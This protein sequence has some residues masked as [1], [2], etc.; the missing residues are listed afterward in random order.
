MKELDPKQMEEILEDIQSLS[1]DTIN[2]LNTDKGEVEHSNLIYYHTLLTENLRS[3][4]KQITRNSYLLIIALTLYFFIFFNKSSVSEIKVLFFEIKDTTLLL[5]FIPIVF[6]F[7]Y[8]RNITLWNNNINLISIFEAVSN[9]IFDLGLFTD[10]VNIIKPFSF[11]H[12]IINYQYENKKIKGI[13]KLPLSISFFVLVFSPIVFNVFS[14]YIISQYNSPS[15]LA[16]LCGVLIGVF[17]LVTIIQ[18][19]NTNK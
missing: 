12:H 6:S 16:Y 17:T 4:N 1:K 15:I 14:I 9:K 19:F 18:A 8:L 11:L 3:N 10:T 2:S 13:F 5:N 7:V